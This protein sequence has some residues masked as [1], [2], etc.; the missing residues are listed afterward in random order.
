MHSY[1]LLKELAAPLFQ[2]SGQQEIEEA[3]G[4]D[5]F[6][7]AYSVFANDRVKARL[8]WD[9]KDGWGFAQISTGNDD[10]KDIPCFLTEA[11]LESVPRNK[12]KIEQFLAL[13]QDAIA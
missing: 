13:L 4:P 2:R 8:V 1:N 9:G 5:V 12:A 3:L 7:S 11:D 10:W 6:G